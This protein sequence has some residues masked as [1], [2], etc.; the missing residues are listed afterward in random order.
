[1]N[2]LIMRF[3]KLKDH[4]LQEVSKTIVRHRY[5]HLWTTLYRSLLFTP[6]IGIIPRDVEKAS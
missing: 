2:A 5:Q 1:M 4:K 3:V 6:K